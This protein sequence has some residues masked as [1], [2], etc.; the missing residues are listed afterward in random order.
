[1]Q[2]DAMMRRPPG[3]VTP[4][5]DFRV[6]GSLTSVFLP[7]LRTRA[8]WFTDPFSLESGFRTMEAPALKPAR[9]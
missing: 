8:V 6:T 1:M 3:D 2:L 7:R 4:V 5:A 9:S